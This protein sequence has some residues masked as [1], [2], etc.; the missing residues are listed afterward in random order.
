MYATTFYFGTDGAGIP[1]VIGSMAG[2][3]CDISL[4]FFALLLHL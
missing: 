2:V 1:A 3:L 4:V